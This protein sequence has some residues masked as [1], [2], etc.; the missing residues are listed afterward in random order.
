MIVPEAYG[1]I[2]LGAVELVA[3]MEVMGEALLCA[4]FFSTVCLAAR[5][6][7]EAGSEAQK[8]AHLPAIAEGQLIATLAVAEASGRFEP[9][10]IEATATRQG[11]GYVLSGE[12]RYVVDG[13]CADLFVVAVR[14]EGSRHGEG[15][16]L[17]LVPGDAAG[18]ARRPLP[19][20]DQTRRQSDIVLS[21][22]RLPAAALMGEE[23]S[24]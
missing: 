6:L 5:A 8:Q 16:S 12:K 17:F 10:G 13:H 7:I 11:D 23:G 14:A 21:D 24:A 15:V 1:G 20:L 18:L 3:L 22:V 19:T 4:P 9:A 2:G